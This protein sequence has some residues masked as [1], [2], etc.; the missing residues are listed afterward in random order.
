[1]NKLEGLTVGE[2][3][4]QNIA[5]A[6][7]FQTHGIDFC[8]GGDILLLEA[9]KMVGVNI[10]E[11]VRDLNAVNT[12]DTVIVRALNFDAWSLDLLI[13][14][15]FKFHHNYIKTEGNKIYELIGKVVKAHG[16]TDPHLREVQSLF[17]ASLVDLN[18]H[19]AKE[20]NILFPFIMEILNTHQR[21]A[22][23]P[24]FHCGSIEN[25]IRVMEQEHNDEGA[26]FRVISELTNS[27]SIPPHACASYKL[28]LEELKQF[29]DNLHIHIH[30]E[31][32]ILFPKA[33]KLQELCR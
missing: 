33:I 29:E 18:E 23:L 19:L 14:Y 11:L 26:R 12:S 10:K 4:S 27:Y 3:V 28:V 31:N 6:K 1:M 25:P 21:G 22:S 24:E 32:N 20:E 16:N 7:V 5:Y 17:A 30:V 15:I 9:V 8:C 13:D 2:I